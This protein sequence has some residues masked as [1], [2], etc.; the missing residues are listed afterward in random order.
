MVV[1]PTVYGTA[2]APGDCPIRG[3][4]ENETN[5]VLIYPKDE[6]TAPSIQ[7]YSSYKT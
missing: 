6:N 7:N 2:P 3:T 4:P 1:A 5:A